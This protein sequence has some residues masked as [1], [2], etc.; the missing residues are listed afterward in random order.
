MIQ[1]SFAS[2]ECALKK[3]RTRREKFLAEMERV[4]PWA[5]LVAV[6]EPL[7]PSSGRVGRQPIGVPRMLR[8]YCLQQWHALADEALEDALYDSTRH[9]S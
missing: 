1:R 4:V 3:K 9:H 7:Y 8:M 6:I 2:A 5:R